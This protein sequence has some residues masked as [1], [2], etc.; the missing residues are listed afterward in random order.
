MD[1]AG[2]GGG[3]VL[4][5]VREYWGAD[6]FG[7]WLRRVALVSRQF[8]QG[9][10]LCDT[11]A[12]KHF[13]RADV[14]YLAY[15]HPYIPFFLVSTGLS[16]IV[17]Q[18]FLT[19]RVVRL[20]KSKLIALPI[21][22]LAIAAFAGCLTTA[23]SYST[24][25]TGGTQQLGIYTGAVW[26]VGAATTDILITSALL[27]VLWKAR[28]SAA[29]FTM[30]SHIMGTLDRLIFMITSTGGMTVI[31]ALLCVVVFL[32]V[33]QG[34]AIGIGYCLGRVYSITV[35]MSLLQGGGGNGG[36]TSAHSMSTHQTKLAGRKT[37]NG[38]AVHHTTTVVVDDEHELDALRVKDGRHRVSLSLECSPR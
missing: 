3:S 36:D 33:D 21:V 18:L 32:A 31:G 28:S 34:I 25:A 30:Q 12:V 9:Q 1:G 8:Y 13:C 24:H 10:V 14:S 17:C 37:V 19:R 7:V 23:I 11:D 29:Q 5:V 22:F 35:M 16:G 6:R 26:L 2:D 27:W 4:S 38:V 20:T 15:N